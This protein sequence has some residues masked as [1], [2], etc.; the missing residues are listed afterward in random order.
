MPELWAHY[1]AHE[2]Y[3]GWSYRPRAQRIPVPVLQSHLHDGGPSSSEWPVRS[4]PLR[5]QAAKKAAKFHTHGS[6]RKRMLL[7]MVVAFQSWLLR[8]AGSLYPPA[9]NFAPGPLGLFVFA[10]HGFLPNTKDTMDLN[11]TVRIV[12]R[13]GPATDLSALR[14]AYERSAVGAA[15]C[16]ADRYYLRM[17]HLPRFV[18]HPRKR[19]GRSTCAL[20]KVAI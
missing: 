10:V 5:H 14:G 8:C 18:R 13:H 3:A 6:Q 16:P 1:V 7:S 9:T 12:V 20:S 15:R 17:P 2:D 4:D 11:T 19:S